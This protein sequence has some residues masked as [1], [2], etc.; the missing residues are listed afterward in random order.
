MF[1]GEEE[2]DSEDD[3]RRMKVLYTAVA[4]AVVVLLTASYFG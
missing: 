2:A 1:L 4:L 3:A